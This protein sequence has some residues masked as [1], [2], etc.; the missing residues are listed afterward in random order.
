MQKIETSE[1]RRTDAKREK[2]IQYSHVIAN[3]ETNT[4]NRQT[5]MQRDKQ[6][7]QADTD[8]KR[9]KWIQQTDMGA[10]REVQQADKW[11]HKERHIDTGKT[12]I[13]T[14]KIYEI[15]DAKIYE[16]KTHE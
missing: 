9:E 7:Q 8:S 4:Y 2:K 1:N 5:C 11:M 10:K 12:D 14:Q 16:T 15:K 3:R 13:E 6:I